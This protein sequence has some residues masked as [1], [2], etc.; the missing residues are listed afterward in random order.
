[1]L[2]I[3]AHILGFL[4]WRVAAAAYGTHMLGF[5]HWRVAAAAGGAACRLERARPPAADF[6]D[7]LQYP[8]G[9]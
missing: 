3:Y 2:Y 6:F 7:D 8:V 5:L 9:P 1:M 4:H